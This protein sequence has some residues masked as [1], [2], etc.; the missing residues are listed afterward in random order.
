MTKESRQ[1]AARL[2]A[3]AWLAG[4]TVD[5]PPELLPT[6]R[7]AAYAVQDEMAR[8]LAVDPAKAV[9]GWKV[10]ATSAGVQKAEGYDGPIPGRIFASTVFQTGAELPQ[11]RCP[12]AAIE[13]EI[14]F[15]FVVPPR[16]S[17][18]QVQHRTAWQT[19][20]G[21][22]SLLRHHQQPL[23]ATVSNQ[24]GQSSEYVGWHRRQWQ[25]RRGRPGRARVRLAKAGFHA[26]GA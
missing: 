11:F 9:V 13:A 7:A 4:V 8:L 22:A 16:P 25:W 17:K 20:R 18:K 12:Y 5:F 26:T 1:R 21:D 15:R 19:M 6:C 10:G 2:L 24:L 23:R 3:D 14:A